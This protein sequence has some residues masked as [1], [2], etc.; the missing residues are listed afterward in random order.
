MVAC[1]GG[2]GGGFE[3][4]EVE[5]MKGLRSASLQMDPSCMMGGGILCLGANCGTHSS[6]VLTAG[7]RR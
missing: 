3:G 2:I 6:G 1:V 5:V 7:G 4:P